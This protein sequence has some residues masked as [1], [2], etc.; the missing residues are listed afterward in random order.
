MLDL[1][2]IR[3]EILKLRTRP[4]MLAAVAV[5]T[6]VGR[7]DRPFRGRRLGHPA[8][9]AERYRAF[10]AELDRYEPVALSVAP[11]GDAFTPVVLR[12]RVTRWLDGEAAWELV[13]RI[14]IAYTGQPYDRIAK[15]TDRDRYVDANEAKAFGLVDDVIQKISD[16]KKK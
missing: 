4:G 2:L 8:L 7:I 5:C 10:I 11:A 15:E 13:D 6:V 14:A 1:R 3:A 12:G 9:F 16:E